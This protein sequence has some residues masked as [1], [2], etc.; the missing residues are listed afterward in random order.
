MAVSVERG[1]RVVPAE[2]SGQNN[3]GDIGG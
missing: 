3:L 2:G 1:V